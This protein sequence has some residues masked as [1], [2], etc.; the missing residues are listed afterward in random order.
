MR[1]FEFYRVNCFQSSNLPLG[2]RDWRYFSNFC[3]L[4]SGSAF[5]PVTPPCSF[6]LSAFLRRPPWEFVIR[7]L[8]ILTCASEAACFFET[9]KNKEYKYLWVNLKL[10]GFFLWVFPSQNHHP[11]LP[12]K[13]ISPQDTRQA[14]KKI[15]SVCDFIADCRRYAQF[16]VPQSWRFWVVV[17]SPLLIFD[18]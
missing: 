8:F 2:I 6:F 14:A 3:A 9:R 16:A 4:L 18:F 15:A 5:F 1:P 7:S 12:K 17:C 10:F 13:K 11:G